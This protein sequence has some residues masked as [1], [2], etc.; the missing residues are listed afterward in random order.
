M[1]AV[2]GQRLLLALG[3]A[4]CVA[5]GVA[6]TTLLGADAPIPLDA[7]VS[8][9][10]DEGA[11]GPLEAAVG[12]CTPGPPVRVVAGSNIQ[13]VPLGSGTPELPVLPSLAPFAVTTDGYVAY[14]DG[15]DQQVKIVRLEPGAVPIAIPGKANDPIV[16]QAQGTTLLVWPA[17]IPVASPKLS[18]LYTFSAKTGL[19]QISASAELAALSADGTR[20][21]VADVSAAGAWQL[22]LM[23]V[24]GTH[25]ITLVSSAAFSYSGQ[26]APTGLFAGSRNDRVLAQWCPTLDS[27]TVHAFTVSSATLLDVP[28]VVDLPLA[29]SN[30]LAY[31]SPVDAQGDHAAILELNPPPIPTNEEKLVVID[32]AT[33]ATAV[34][35]DLVHNPGYFFG[36]G[37]TETVSY[38][39]LGAMGTST[40]SP[41]DA[42]TVG[43]VDVGQYGLPSVDGTHALVV[44]GDDSPNGDEFTLVLATMTPPFGVDALSSIPALM[45]D[46]WTADGTHAI[47][48]DIP[49]GWQNVFTPLKPGTLQAVDANNHS[50]QTL[51]TNVWT[52]RALS[53]DR[54]AA[55]AGYIVEPESS[56]PTLYF[57]TGAGDL[58]VYDFAANP[59]AHTLVASNVQDLTVTQDRCQIVYTIQQGD[60]DADGLWI[61]TP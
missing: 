1:H 16:S 46:C 33:G 7:S 25:E 60:P 5:L 49:G 18:S 22:R 30:E 21:L 56:T 50:H 3:L 2:L 32:L 48:V 11:D 23:D 61:V 57:G 37:P 51:D 10:V 52:A 28:F 24:D 36:S 45:P 54:I 29:N 6:C 31:G 15:T 44:A 12:S 41:V 20:V 47:W 43:V 40:L 53:G 26:C 13:L 55:L 8:A 35:D 59:A 58:T 39:T 19:T 34:A 14:V 42:K 17:L 9:E 27:Y 4:S 38:F